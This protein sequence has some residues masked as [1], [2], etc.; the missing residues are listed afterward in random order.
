MLEI[1]GALRIPKYIEIATKPGLVAD[2]CGA[3]PS[4]GLG[5]MDLG[6]AKRQRIRKTSLRGDTSVGD[7]IASVFDPVARDLNHPPE[8]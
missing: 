3:I 6:N 8:D 1:R 7:I 4:R 5:S 2:H